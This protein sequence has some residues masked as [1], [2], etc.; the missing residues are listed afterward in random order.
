MGD[1]PRAAPMRLRVRVH[2]VSR[3]T[4]L[5]RVISTSALDRTSITT[6]LWQ[7][8][9]AIFS[10]RADLL[11]LGALFRLA[12]AGPHSAIYLPLRDN[13]P[14]ES[15]ANWVGGGRELADLVVVRRDAHLRPSTWPQ[16][17]ARLRRGAPATMRAAAPRPR[18]DGRPKIDTRDEIRVYECASTVLMSASAQVLLDAGDELT[19]CADQVAISPDI[20]RFGGPVAFSQFNGAEWARGPGRR[21]QSWECMVLAEDPSFIH[22]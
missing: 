9:G 4:T 18:P 22:R 7:H 16:L 15:A 17:R 20:H 19:W 1:E 12:A 8:S 21:D 5:Q 6:M 2:P 11:R 10:C 3:G 14:S 13:T